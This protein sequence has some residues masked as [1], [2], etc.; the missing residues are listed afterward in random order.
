VRAKLSKEL[1]ILKN[2]MSILKTNKGK[3]NKGLDRQGSLA[4]RVKSEKA[5]VKELTTDAKVGAAEQRSRAAHQKETLANKVLGERVATVQAHL[6]KL[7]STAK[8]QQAQV[9][10]ELSKEKA[11]VKKMKGAYLLL[12]R[13]YHLFRREFKRRV[14]HGKK[15]NAERTKALKNFK[16]KLGK[17]LQ[18]NRALA[19]L[20]KKQKEDIANEVEGER[21]QTAQDAAEFQS[22]KKNDAMKLR[23]VKT[24][25]TSTLE[26]LTHVESKLR[27]AHEAL[28]RGKADRAN[29]LREIEKL[30]EQLRLEERIE[31]RELAKIRA[32]T[33]HFGHVLRR[34]RAKIA[35]RIQ[36]EKERE[37]QELEDVKAK[38]TKAANRATKHAAQ[39]MKELKQKKAWTIREL[40]SISV[41]NRERLR[42]LKLREANELRH[43]AA[44]NNRLKESIRQEGV[45]IALQ[46]EHLKHMA[47]HAL[48]GVNAKDANALLTNRQ[49]IHLLAH[50][51]KE[52]ARALKNLRAE[53][54]KN[55]RKRKNRARLEIARSAAQATSLGHQLVQEKV[56]A[57]R[58]LKKEEARE[59]ARIKREGEKD[60]LMLKERASKDEHLAQELSHEKT[61]ASLMLRQQRL[62]EAN[63]RRKERARVTKLL[64]QRIAKER[65]YS[66]EIHMLIMEEIQR[67]ISL[68]REEAKLDD[69]LKAIIAKQ[70]ILLGPLQDKIKKLLLIQAP[71]MKGLEQF[72]VQEF[73]LR[74]LLEREETVLPRMAWKLLHESIKFRMKAKELKYLRSRMADLHDEVNGNGRKLKHALLYESSLSH[75]LAMKKLE[76]IQHIKPMQSWMATYE[77]ELQ[78]MQH[79]NGELDQKKVKTLKKIGQTKVVV[80]QL[81]AKLVNGKKRLSIAA[82]QERRLLK[83]ISQIEAKASQIL[84]KV[85]RAKSKAIQM[86]TRIKRLKVAEVKLKLSSAQTA[87]QARKDDDKVKSLSVQIDK[88]RVKVAAVTRKLNTI[89]Q[90]KKIKSENAKLAEE[91]R[92]LKLKRVKETDHDVLIGRKEKRE[93]AWERSA[94]SNLEKLLRVVK[95][96]QN[97]LKNRQR[98]HKNL[99]KEKDHRMMLLH[100]IAQLRRKIAHWKDA[101]EKVREVNKKRNQ[102][103][104]L[105]LKAVHEI[106]LALAAARR[107]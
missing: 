60:A 23:L 39:V 9:T 40:H 99:E 94:K 13:A 11:K 44:K 5:K 50:D 70:T 95:S 56:T 73:H 26:I 71:A 19:L 65:Q 12:R 78:G 83:E 1:K 27:Q 3:L 93:I 66:H 85:E 37:R 38:E 51:Q 63:R 33:I 87:D 69:R 7:R 77:K 104:D 58:E 98:V 20:L 36:L 43:I 81:K 42:R 49:L 31:E 84:A 6:V 88:E 28:L 53:E 59:S 102:S 75:K 16:L 72:R 91:L 64:R 68:K 48:H 57:A 30:R 74:T 101:V 25:A 105:K 34:E 29:W 41:A 89:R 15:Y 67:E 79:K 55:L 10:A 90:V 24:R 82:K 106:R 46:L 18:K 62:F 52:M 8:V 45:R 21:K 54:S 100:R 32:R 92:R 2:A 22:V 86:E 35:K 96:S 17:L 47:V 97:D 107:R 61:R 14:K 4:E 76:V 103:V 80:K